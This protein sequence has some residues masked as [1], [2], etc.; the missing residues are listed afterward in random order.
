LLPEAQ[1]MLGNVAGVYDYDWKEAERLILLAMS[2]DPVPPW[3]HSWHGFFYLMPTG[4][5]QDGIVAMRRALQGDPLNRIFRLCLTFGL[6]AAERY[7]EATTEC[8][9]LSE[10][11]E[12]YW[13][14]Y[15]ALSW[16]LVLRKQF[17]EAL[18]PAEK[19][20]SLAPWNSITT[21]S[22]AAALRLNGNARRADEVLQP[23][24]SATEKY[25]A[26]RGLAVFHFLC[27]EIDQAADWLEKSLAERDPYGPILSPWFLRSS[28]RWPAVAKMMN[29]LGQVS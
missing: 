3:V 26:P 25:A 17:A 12:N 23:L 18:A 7:E 27:G 21:G 20:H 29:W 9:Q 13:F 22:L 2:R 8:R 4:R 16:S 28:E 10:I 1:G 11:D 19:G 24:R 6:M 5:P 15:S 14:G